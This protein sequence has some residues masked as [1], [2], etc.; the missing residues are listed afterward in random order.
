VG[1]LGGGASAGGGS[2]D[3]LSTCS[4]RPVRGSLANFMAGEL[5]SYRNFG[6]KCVSSA[7]DKTLCC[8]EVTRCDG[9]QETYKAE[10]F[11]PKSGVESALSSAPKP[12][13]CSK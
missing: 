2:S 1:P 7:K 13:G 3:P 4:G 10:L 8:V 11:A 5:A 6:F 12:K 9:K